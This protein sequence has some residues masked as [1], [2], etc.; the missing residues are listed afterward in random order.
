MTRHI[1]SLLARKQKFEIPSD[2]TSI[3][4]DTDSTSAAS[5]DDNSFT[6]QVTLDGDH[7]F[8]PLPYHSD[9]DDS[10]NSQDA[11]NPLVPE[12]TVMPIIYNHLG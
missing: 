5:S 9:P 2:D 8:E 7:S 3:S 1:N 10:V 4:S 6:L 12:P 11:D